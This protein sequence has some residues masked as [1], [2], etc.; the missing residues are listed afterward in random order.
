MQKPCF[1]PTLLLSMLALTACGGGDNTADPSPPTAA[2]S[3]HQ[4]R[5][6]QS[7]PGNGAPST[8]QRTAAVQIIVSTDPSCTG[9]SPFYW[10]IGDAGG[11][12]ASGIGG[13]GSST[14]PGPDTMMPIAS[15]SKWVFSTWIMQQSWGIP[16]DEE[17]SLLRL[18][19]G[20]SNMSTCSNTGT[21][22]SCLSEPGQVG[23]TNG[24]KLSKTVDRFYYNGGHMQMLAMR[25]GLGSKDAA[26]M[27]AMLRGA[28]GGLSSGMVYTNPQAGGGIY[29][30]ANGFA[31]FL[32]GLLKGDYTAMA[33]Q[34]GTYTIC[35]HT[36]DPT[37]T[38]L[39]SPM[40]QTKPNGPNDVSEEAWHYS[41][42]HWVEDDP[43]NGDG[44]FSSPGRFG[45]YPWIDADKKWYGMV[46]RY[47]TSGAS[48]VVKRRGSTGIKPTAGTA[49]SAGYLSS[50]CGRK[51]R[52][53]WLNPLD[54]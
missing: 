49:V 29:S 38:A 26:G 52:W 6:T 53:A 12:R 2:A 39:Y 13:N 15:T 35:T 3:A 18:T 32:R 46:A 47:D 31:T 36:N 24:D 4:M 23:G 33:A 10:E 40:N 50:V 25:R 16:T 14:A 34:L 45:F 41:L 5:P 21:V 54:F 27:T 11:M 51:M 37:C 48:V 7:M 8:E 20:Y 42:G 9:L 19:S 1:F 22:E 17:L 28:L 30:S 44:A 43:H